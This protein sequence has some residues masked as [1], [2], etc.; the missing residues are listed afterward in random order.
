MH[1]SLARRWLRPQSVAVLLGVLSACGGARAHSGTANPVP[2]EVCENA[3]IGDTCA[4]VDHHEMLNR[5]TCRSSG[6]ALLCVRHK[7]LVHVDEPTPGE[8]T[9]ASPAILA[10]SFGGA[11]GALLVVGAAARRRT[12]APGE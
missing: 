11:C 7:P 10:M 12:P 3:S 6:G 4:F 5:G 9:A 8:A 1:R 2:W